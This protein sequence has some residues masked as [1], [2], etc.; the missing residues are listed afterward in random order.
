MTVIK[1]KVVKPYTDDQVQMHAA[2]V[3]GTRNLREVVLVDQDEQTDYVFL[4]KKPSRSVIQ[5]VTEANSRNNINASSKVLMGCVLEGDMEVLEH[6]GSM[7]LSMIEHV[8]GLMNRVKGD[9]KKV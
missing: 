8:T 6:D 2:K 5:A 1:N 4:L 9:L 3:G 7:Y